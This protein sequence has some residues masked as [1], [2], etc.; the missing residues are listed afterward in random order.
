MEAEHALPYA[1]FVFLLLLLLLLAQS[2][3]HSL[4]FIPCVCLSSVFYRIRL[5]VVYRFHI[6]ATETSCS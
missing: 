1:I 3:T 2:L 6:Y 5:C 4:P